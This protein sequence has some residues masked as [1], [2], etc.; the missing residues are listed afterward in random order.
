MS[1][2]A[3]QEQMVWLKVKTERMQKLREKFGFIP[4]EYCYGSI[5]E[6]SDLWCAEGHHNNHDRRD[7]VFRNARILHRSCNQL[8]EDK[9]V[10]DVPS[11]L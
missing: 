8:I 10:R 9:N 5:V 2:K 3:K 11:L 6:G 7:N 4:C 1:D